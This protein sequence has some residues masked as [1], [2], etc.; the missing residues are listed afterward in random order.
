MWIST[1]WFASAQYNRI[2]VG[3]AASSRVPLTWSVHTFVGALLRGRFLLADVH[4]VAELQSWSIFFLHCSQKKVDASNFFFFF[5]TRPHDN[6]TVEGQL[7]PLTIFAVGG[8]GVAVSAAAALWRQWVSLAQLTLKVHNSLFFLTACTHWELNKETIQW[9]TL[10]AFYVH[11][12]PRKQIIL[13]QK[14]GVLK[15]NFL[16]FENSIS[17]HLV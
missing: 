11:R 14:V 5:F 6:L 15:K 17:F 12:K 13:Y 4:E 2:I 10:R 16:N 3:P 1:H 7:G 9:E 8:V